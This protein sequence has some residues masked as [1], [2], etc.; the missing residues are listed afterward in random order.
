MLLCVSKF[1][2][3]SDKHTANKRAY[4]TQL[5]KNP[6]TILNQSELN[7]L[8]QQLKT[9]VGIVTKIKITSPAMEAQ[10][11]E[12]LKPILTDHLISILHLP[13][14][15]DTRRQL[16]AIATSQGHARLV[17]TLTVKQQSDLLLS[18]PQRTK[19][20]ETVKESLATYEESITRQLANAVDKQEAK[21]IEMLVPQLSSA[22][23]QAIDYRL[24]SAA[25][26]SR[27][28]IMV[29]TLL[30]TL[31]VA[32]VRKAVDEHGNTIV[33]LA[34]MNGDAPTLETILNL[35]GDQLRSPPIV[36]D[37]GASPLILAAHNGHTAAVRLLQ[38]ISQVNHNPKRA[39]TALYNAASQGHVEIVRLLTTEPYNADV[40]IP[41]PDGSAA[42]HLA[43]EKGHTE[44]VELLLNK[45]KSSK[46][47]NVQRS[48]G[49]TALKMAVANGHPAIVRLLAKRSS[50]AD[51]V[52]ET[53]GINI[54]RILTNQDLANRAEILKILLERVDNIPKSSEKY[55][56]KILNWAVYENELEVIALLVKKLPPQA[57]IADVD[58]SSP[59]LHLA[60]LQGNVEALQ[61]LKSVLTPLQINSLSKSKTTA[62][63][64]AAENGHVA[65][66]DA[67]VK[68]LDDNQVGFFD[69]RG[70]SAL[71][72]AA[73]KG[74]TPAVELLISRL[75]HKP[76]AL[77][78]TSPPYNVSALCMAVAFNKTTTAA[79]LIPYLSVAEIYTPESEGDTALHFAAERGNIEL[80]RLL[81]IDGVSA[82]QMNALN[83]K[84]YS[85]LMRAIEKGHTEI[86]E[87]LLDRLT[88][89]EQINLKGKMG[90]ALFLAANK[91][92]EVIVAKILAA[93][94]E[95]QCNEPCPCCQL[96]PLFSAI[97]TENISV[98][99]SLLNKLESEQLRFPEEGGMT[100][101]HFSIRGKKTAATKVLL[102]SPKININDRRC[103]ETALHLAVKNN[104][105][106]AVA[107]LL[108]HSDIN[109]FL[110]DNKNKTALQQAL[111]QKI[112]NE[113]IIAALKTKEKEAESALS[114]MATASFLSPSST[115]ASTADICRQFDAKQDKVDSGFSFE[116]SWQKLIAQQASHNETT[117]KH[118]LTGA[119]RYISL[120]GDF[121]PPADLPVPLDAKAAFY[122]PSDKRPPS[123]L[124]Q[125]RMAKPHY[126]PVVFDKKKNGNKMYIH[127]SDNVIKNAGE[128]AWKDLETFLNRGNI[129]FADSVSKRHGLK[130]LTGIK[131]KTT[132]WE[133]SIHNEELGD[134]RLRTAIDQEPTH[135]EVLGNGEKITV[136]ELDHYLDHSTIDARPITFSTR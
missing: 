134:V 79:A 1:S 111:A 131:S 10:V 103:G 56:I 72:M 76:G 50:S 107:L 49:W 93:L 30:E 82:A 113:K 119:Q 62:L 40:S 69:S 3:K 4:M 29:K 87:L 59:A 120:L 42:L 7:N 96:T 128:E 65:V 91:G 26:K 117:K 16:L 20:Q 54:F 61:I 66:M 125:S 100:A 33:H 68:E 98:L 94:N 21:A 95:K 11:A 48:N 90:T 106:S 52:L 67:L 126:Y 133:L 101:L 123:A 35:A 129:G 46:E 136:L 18:K 13:F 104:D 14:L 41:M 9:L 12:K 6:Q 23:Q 77:N 70:I 55:A 122:Q 71:H 84:G 5:K 115:A 36:N 97:S 32:A 118:S 80:V 15:E 25:A 99:T 105:E 44:I 83:K 17:T 2:S 27:N 89:P 110:V 135:E 58:K 130:K 24:L 60:A 8:E 22:Q 132:V 45:L 127:V 31:G 78:A 34:A 92:N 88:T 19:L 75:K 39:H 51:I 73:L 81:L 109:V 64:A 47:V 37:I 63:Y 114:Q 85:P 102:A 86:A 124:P 108:A 43:C 28:P 74:H 116:R 53:K 112:P 57:I 38:P 121:I